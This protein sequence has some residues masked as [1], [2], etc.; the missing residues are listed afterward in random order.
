MNRFLFV[1]SGLLVWND[2]SQHHSI[3]ILQKIG[4]MTIYLQLNYSKIVNL[5][6]QTL[7]VT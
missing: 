5:K 7:A 2:V 3:C 6:F 4:S 1:N